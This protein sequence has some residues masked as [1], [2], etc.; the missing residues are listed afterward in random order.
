MNR[1]DSI[2][3]IA[4]ALNKFQAEITNPKKTTTNPFFGSKYAPL[5]QILDH[6]RSTLGEC[7]LSFIQSVSG[8]GEASSVATLLMHT[9]GEWIESDLLTFPNKSS[10]GD[11]LAQGGGAS[12]T[13][14]RRYSLEAILGIS[15]E[16]DDD[17]N[18]ASGNYDNQKKETNKPSSKALSK[19]PSNPGDLIYPCGS[20]RGKKLS[21]V[22]DKDLKW[23][24]ENGYQ[25]KMKKAAKSLLE[26]R[27]SKEKE[28]SAR[29]HEIKEIINGNQV[30]HNDVIN[31]LKSQ[32]EDKGKKTEID[33]LSED[34]Y[35]GL[36]DF[37]GK[38]KTPEGQ[39]VEIDPKAL[40]D[41]YS[42]EKVPWES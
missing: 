1:S 37:L 40:D 29:Q 31:Y 26:S 18:S 14:A 8:G 12:I 17:G 4:S 7:G 25:K 33:D 6:I 10:K 30:L 21:E 19:S 24:A 42:N 2:K 35:Q 15:A 3:N 20:S 36:I 23:L 39:D 27:A 22:S 13:Y 28:L 41:F 9:S 34:E 11:S 32:T 16:K 5:G 38:I